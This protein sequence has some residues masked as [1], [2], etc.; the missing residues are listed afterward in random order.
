MHLNGRLLR[1]PAAAG[2]RTV[3][4]TDMLPGATDPPGCT[5]EEAQQ[6]HQ[7]ATPGS[8][9]YTDLL[10][11]QLK[12]ATLFHY[13]CEDGLMSGYSA[14]DLVTV[15]IKGLD[16]SVSVPEGNSTAQR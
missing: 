7:P 12:L 8:V 1:H 14:G 5:T 10:I 9:C 2:Q 3:A 11:L 4:E 13:V 6:T 15:N 16:Y